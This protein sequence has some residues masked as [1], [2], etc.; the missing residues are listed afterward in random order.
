M[1]SP[2]LIDRF[3]EL[4]AEHDLSAGNRDGSVPK[5]AR[6]LGLT[7]SQGNTVMQNIRRRLGPQAR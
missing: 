4:L 2:P 7:T 3:A 1:K 6:G 5:V